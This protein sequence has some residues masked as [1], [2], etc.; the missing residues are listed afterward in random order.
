MEPI[1][2]PAGPEPD[3]DGDVY[4]SMHSSMYNLGTVEGEEVEPQAPGLT[5]D[6][7]GQRSVVANLNLDDD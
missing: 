6:V 7:D 2:V 1:P 5:L 4:Y 3:E